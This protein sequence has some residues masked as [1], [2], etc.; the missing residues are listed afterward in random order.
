MPRPKSNNTVHLSFWA[1]LGVPERIERILPHL[2]AE[3]FVLTRA[4]A[5]RAALL[6]GLTGLEMDHGLVKH[7]VTKR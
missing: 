7:K 5:L 4:D 6:R 3:G 1:P 2:T